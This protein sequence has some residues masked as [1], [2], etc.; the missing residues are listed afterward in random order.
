MELSDV[1]ESED[2]L[3]K[4]ND[5]LVNNI[6]QNTVNLEQLDKINVVLNG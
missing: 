3:K 1:K 2:R 4:L 6:N 5:N